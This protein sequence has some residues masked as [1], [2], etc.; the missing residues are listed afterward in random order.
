MKKQSGLFDVTMG[1]YDGAEACKLVGT[2]MLSL[3]SEKHNK[4]DFGVYRDGGL[5]VVKTKSGPETEKF[6][7]KIQKIFKENKLDIVIKC[8]MKLVNYL[9]VT[10]NLNN[11]NYKPYHKTGNEISY[12]HKDSN[13]PLSILNQ[14]PKS[15][16]KRISTLSSNETIFNESKEI[17]QKA[18]EKSGYR[19][20]LKYH[21][22]NEN[23]SNNKR[24][25]KRNVIWFNP[26]F[27]ANVK[28]KVGNYFSESYKKALSPTS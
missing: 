14:I 9:D 12:I 5:G 27:S 19:Q 28:T 16:E 26:P 22:P 23:V 17:Y 18:L 7:K 3:I 21:P 10:L 1:A 25:T 24:N 13:H 15:I 2:Y 8:N 20:T 11:S 4:K 6:K